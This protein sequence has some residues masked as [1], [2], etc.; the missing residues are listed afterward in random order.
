M[1]LIDHIFASA[2]ARHFCSQ[3]KSIQ[4]EIREQFDLGFFI[5]LLLWVLGFYFGLVLISNAAKLIP[6]GPYQLFLVIPIFLLPVLLSTFVGRLAIYVT[7]CLEPYY[8]ITKHYLQRLYQKTKP[9][10]QRYHQVAKLILYFVSQRIKAL[11]SQFNLGSKGRRI[12]FLICLA[13]CFIMFGVV[14]IQPL[15]V[16]VFL[17]LT[18]HMHALALSLES[19]NFKL[20]TGVIEVIFAFRLEMLLKFL[21]MFFLFWLGF[22]ISLLG[23][24]GAVAYEWTY[25]KV[26]R[27]VNNG[28]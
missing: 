1:K 4:D 27:W 7:L 16:R 5:L 18:T 19:F 10:L 13:G 8:Q 28:V 14:F 3:L 23:A 20:D 11:L 12:S 24:I 6:P 25:E 9:R 17:K 26:I 21:F 22:V 15:P 2:K